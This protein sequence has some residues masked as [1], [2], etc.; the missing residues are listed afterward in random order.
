MDE[1]GVLVLVRDT[2]G[3]GLFAAL[4]ETTGRRPLFP[5]NGERP[6]V[7]VERLRPP[8]ILLECHHPAARSDAFF[9]AVAGAG[10]R[11]ILFS[12]GAL[13]DDC[14]EIARRHGIEAFVHPAPGE[15]LAELVQ[16]AL[17]AE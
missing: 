8:R 14:G 17:A 6:E 11:V 16:R 3:G 9:I 7:A 12:P 2:L 5:L 10:G 1:E 15:S 13:W 4:A